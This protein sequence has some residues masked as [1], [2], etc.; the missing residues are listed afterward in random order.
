ITTS[1]KPALIGVGKADPCKYVGLL[2]Q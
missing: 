2:A 1:G